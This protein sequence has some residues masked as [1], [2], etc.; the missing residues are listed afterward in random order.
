[1]LLG[2]KHRRG[3]GEVHLMIAKPQRFLS[4]R[5]FLGAG[6]HLR[7]PLRSQQRRLI[8]NGRL[9]CPS[10]CGLGIRRG[11][12]CRL[13][14]AEQ[15]VRNCTK[16]RNQHNR[17]NFLRCLPRSQLPTL[18]SSTQRGNRGALSLFSFA[19][20]TLLPKH[21]QVHMRCPAVPCDLCSKK[22]QSWEIPGFL[23][24]FM[25]CW[26]RPGCSIFHSCIPNCLIRWLRISTPAAPPRH[27]RPNLA[28]SY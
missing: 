10:V 5:L 6:R 11:R 18:H 9:R 21:L 8:H 25:F 17:G 15:S 13:S 12:T 28:F 1:M 19:I 20:C 22:E 4:E 27:G 7:Q 16:Q 24:L 26:R 2:V 14:R 3:K 23:S